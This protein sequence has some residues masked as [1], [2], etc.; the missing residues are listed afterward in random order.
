MCAEFHVFIL[1]IADFRKESFDL[2]GLVFKVPIFRMIALGSEQSLTT[3]C[4]IYAFCWLLL[5]KN[6][7]CEEFAMM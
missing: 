6:Y 1:Q 7:V 2:L 3:S 4:I 5:L